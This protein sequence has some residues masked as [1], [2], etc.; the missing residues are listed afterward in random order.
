MAWG[1]T[2]RISRLIKISDEAALIFII[3][4]MLFLIS[5]IPFGGLLMH[6]AYRRHGIILILLMSVT[7]GGLYFLKGKPFLETGSPED[8]LKALWNMH[9]SLEQRVNQNPQ[10]IKDLLALA[11]VEERLG[12][13]QK[14]VKC[15]TELRALQ[16]PTADLILAELEARLHHTPSKI[17]DD[18]QYLMKLGKEIFP[19]D[20][21]LQEYIKIIEETFF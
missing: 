4:M 21:R 16:K 11:T 9:L 20:Q 12:N 1:I 5:L 8:H 6:S 13:Y 14:A 3:F 19:S 2:N 10:S 17:S 15:Y 7:A 18:V